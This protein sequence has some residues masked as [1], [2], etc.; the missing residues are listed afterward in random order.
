M[1]WTGREE[2]MKLWGLGS[3]C[4]AD[5][6]KGRYPPPVNNSLLQTYP[7]TSRAAYRQHP[8]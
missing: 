1:R 3:V 7:I 2:V 8:F 6:A 4:R 5:E